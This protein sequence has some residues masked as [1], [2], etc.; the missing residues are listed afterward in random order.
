MTTN[1][2]CVRAL[3]IKMFLWLPQPS[4]LTSVESIVRHKKYHEEN[5]RQIN[6]NVGFENKL[7]FYN[8]IICMHV[9]SKSQWITGM[10]FF[11]PANPVLVYFSTCL[12]KKYNTYFIL[13]K[14]SYYA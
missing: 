8:C 7:Y 12:H 14:V 10:F 5:G 11:C 4:C 3:D 13:S 9:K 2:L 6:G 1:L